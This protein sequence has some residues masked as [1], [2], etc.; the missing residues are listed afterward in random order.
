[1]QIF[2]YRLTDAVN[3]KMADFKEMSRTGIMYSLDQHM[4]LELEVNFGSMYFVIPYGGLYTGYESFN[5]IFVCHGFYSKQ[6]CQ[7]S[8]MGNPFTI[9]STS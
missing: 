6:N 4:K 9:E 2:F 1:M 7:K 5:F 3:V 8:V